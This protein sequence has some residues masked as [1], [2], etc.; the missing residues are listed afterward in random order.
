MHLDL[1]H[2]LLQVPSSLVG[3]QLGALYSSLEKGTN[4]T[5]G[6]LK[7]V[8]NSDLLCCEPSRSYTTA[9]RHPDRNTSYLVR[10]S[11][12][13]MN[14]NGKEY[15]TMREYSNGND[16]STLSMDDVVYVSGDQSNLSGL[17]GRKLSSHCPN[18][19]RKSASAS[20]L[21]LGS[22]PHFVS[23]KQKFFELK[24][25]KSI[26]DVKDEHIRLMKARLHHRSMSL[27]KDDLMIS[28]RGRNPRPPHQ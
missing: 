6:S 19:L 26:D 20:Q 4:V 25:N 27:P 15:T 24:A 28:G 3:S 18:K 9:G 8:G 14:R 12:G 2:T 5:S 7:V 21:N 1:F 22:K 10:D 16:V 17:H 13:H 11:T 23:H